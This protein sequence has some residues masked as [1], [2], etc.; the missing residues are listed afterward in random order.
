[1]IQRWEYFII[2][3]KTSFTEKISGSMRNH[4]WRRQNDKGHDV[5]NN[6]YHFNQIYRQRVKIMGELL[7]EFHNFVLTSRVIYRKL[8]EESE[9]L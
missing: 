1:M 6:S 7:G 9:K 4:T 3:L 5:I 2:A 8:K